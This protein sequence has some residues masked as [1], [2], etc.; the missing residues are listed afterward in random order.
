[1]R[2]TVDTNVLVSSSF[3]QGDSNKILEKVENK[4]LCLVLSNEIIKEFSRVLNYEEIQQKIRDKNLEMKRTIEKIISISEIIEP[5]T[6]INVLKEDPDDNIILECA[7]EGRADYIVTQDNHLL[8]LGNFQNIK[9]I[10]PE[11]LMN[12]LKS[13]KVESNQKMTQEYSELTTQAKNEQVQRFVV[14]A[15]ITKDSKYLFLERKKEDFM[16]GIYE[17]PSGKVEENESLIQALKREVKEE[18]GLDMIDVKK[19]VSG[20][21]YKS[22]S[23]KLTRQFNFIVN[24][25]DTD[26]ILLTEHERYAWLSKK[27]FDKFP[28]T[29]STKEIFK[30]LK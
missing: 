12:M 27:E 2:I 21:D 6:K 17:L 14:G 19:Y 28:I 1:M 10:T 11:E 24:V 4:E 22:G 3:W 20:F 18:T 8:K 30:I 25:K 26:N 29:E 7:L 13:N 5:K 23:G 15:I 16:G 9:I